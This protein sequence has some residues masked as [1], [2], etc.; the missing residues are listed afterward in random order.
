M[1]KVPR[2]ARAPLNLMRADFENILLYVRLRK[3]PFAPLSANNCATTTVNTDREWRCVVA[4][5]W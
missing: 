2:W 3:M 1:W 5:R 4:L